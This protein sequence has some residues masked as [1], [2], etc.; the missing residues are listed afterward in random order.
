MANLTY[1]PLR[2]RSNFAV[3][4]DKITEWIPALDKRSPMG[5]KCTLPVAVVE[6]ASWSP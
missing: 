5:F 4:D 2:E 1:S 3:T 6:P